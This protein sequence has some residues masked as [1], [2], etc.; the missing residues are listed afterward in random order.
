MGDERRRSVGVD[1]EHIVR[2]SEC[3]RVYAGAITAAEEI[4]PAGTDGSC[5][6]GN[7]EFEVVSTSDRS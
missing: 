5:R 1:P 4:H 7:D 6:C 2:C 3:E